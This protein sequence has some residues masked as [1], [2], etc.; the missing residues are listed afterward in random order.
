MPLA[1][2]TAIAVI[3]TTIEH[4]VS[5]LHQTK[6]VAR[7]ARHALRHLERLL[8]LSYV[9][10]AEAVRMPMARPELEGAAL[11]IDQTGVGRPVADIF[12]AAGPKP[13]GLLIT[14]GQE[15]STGTGR[16]L[17][18]AKVQ[19]ISMLQA[20]LHDGSLRIAKG[21]PEAAV[22]AHELAEFRVSFTAAGAM[23]F[24]ARVGRHDD[25][26][27]ALAIALWQAALPKVRLG[28]ARVV[29]GRRRP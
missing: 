27:L 6:V 9:E 25:L 7:P 29:V 8:G 15:A 11:V 13:T 21:L 18:V 20:K 28:T 16:A 10:Q 22:L 24:G 12:R 2:H 14:G 5:S 4:R 3:E 17:H 19:L 23:T 26:V 1:H